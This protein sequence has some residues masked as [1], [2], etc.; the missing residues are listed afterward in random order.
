MKKKKR[1]KKKKKKRKNKKKNKKNK[2]KQIKKN[3]IYIL[4]LFALLSK[5]KIIYQINNSK[6]QI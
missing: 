3:D 6:K 5:Y 4:L 2:N 1:K